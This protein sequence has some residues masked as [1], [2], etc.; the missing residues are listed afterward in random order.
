MLQVKGKDNIKTTKKPRK[1][2]KRNYLKMQ[3]VSKKG[4]VEMPDGTVFDLVKAVYSIHRLQG[5]SVQKIAEEIV[6]RCEIKQSVQGIRN[7]LAETTQAK[8]MH[9][10]ALQDAYPQATNGE[11]YEEINKAFQDSVEAHKKDNRK[12]EAKLRQVKTKYEELLAAKDVEIK[13]YQEIAMNQATAL[14]GKDSK[15]NYYESLLTKN[16]ISYGYAVAAAG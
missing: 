6:K 7:V 9:V 12:N 5:V 14:L 13:K 8:L 3:A 11:S 15:I 16:S 1:K 2:R 4:R 10:M